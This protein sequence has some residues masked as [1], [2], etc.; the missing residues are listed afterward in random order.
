MKAVALKIHIQSRF[1]D[2]DTSV[3]LLKLS[4]WEILCPE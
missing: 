2:Q 1:S 3:Q 4:N